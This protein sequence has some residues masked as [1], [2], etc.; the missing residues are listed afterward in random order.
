[1]KARIIAAVLVVFGLVFLGIGISM[2]SQ[3]GVDCND[4]AMQPGEMCHVWKKNRGYVDQTYDE[5]R[6]DASGG[7]WILIGFGTLVLASGLLRTV[8]IVRQHRR[9]ASVPGHPAAPGAAIPPTGLPAYQPPQSGPHPQ[10]SQS[11]PYSYP[12]RYAS[13]A[14]EPNRPPVP[15]PP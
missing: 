3:R 8:F 15:S 5:Q 12:P 7:G 9:S 10:S 11:L 2:V 14:H 1:M 13:P 6:S 4:K